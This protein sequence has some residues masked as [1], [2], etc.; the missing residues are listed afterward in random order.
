MAVGSAKKFWLCR[1][2]DYAERAVIGGG[3]SWSGRRES[4]ID[5]A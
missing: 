3:P 5:S 2:R 4:P 1:A